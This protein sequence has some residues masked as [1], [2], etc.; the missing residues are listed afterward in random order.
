MISI[1]QIGIIALYVE[2]WIVIGLFCFS[3][4]KS[5]K[6]NLIKAYYESVAE[7]GRKANK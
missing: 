7:N 3:I 2:A 1:G 5:T 4:M 6:D